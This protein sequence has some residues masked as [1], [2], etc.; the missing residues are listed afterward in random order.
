M[1]R[2]GKLTIGLLLLLTTMS[3]CGA[4]PA[5]SQ[6][7]GAQRADTAEPL[8]TRTPIAPPAI[9]T[10]MPTPIASPSPTTAAP[11]EATATARQMKYRIVGYY[12]AWSS[13]TRDGN[14]SDLPGNMLTHV[15]YAFSSIDPKKHT[16]V[17]GAESV[18]KYHF[19]HL[20]QLKQEYPHLKVLIAIGGATRS[21]DFSD[22]AA[23]AETREKFVKSCLD[24]YLDTHGDVFDGIDL[25]WEFPG[26]GDGSREED[27]Q[28]FTLLMKEF[29]RQLDALGQQKKR[30]YLL[31]A[32]TPAGAWLL[33]QYELKEL[34]PLLDWFNVMTYDFSG[35]WSKE[36]NFTAPLYRAKDDPFPANNVD[37]TVQAYLKAGVL[38]HKITLGI[39]FYGRGWTTMGKENNGL[40]QDLGRGKISGTAFTYRNLVENYIGK[41]DYKRFWSYGAKVPWL[42]NATDRVFITYEDPDSIGYKADY[43]IDHYLG[44][45]M[46][47]HLSSDADDVLL[48]TLHDRLAQ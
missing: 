19:K 9:A 32:A 15:I 20:R 31:T 5:A 18:D 14:A 11:L 22:M 41:N 33:Q 26:V 7:I 48:Q 6:P 21:K 16:C 46:I 28:N 34:A 38:P 25:D 3:A 1:S 8:L 17:Y 23:K 2:M 24:L 13:P 29:R 36:T 10:F 43:V 39:P 35:A 42:F 30:S 37:A 12:P 45:A 40:Y 47:W 4:P 27:T 44:G